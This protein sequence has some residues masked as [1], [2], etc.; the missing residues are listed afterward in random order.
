MVRP[1]VEVRRAYALSAPRRSAEPDGGHQVRGDPHAPRARAVLGARIAGRSALLP[2]TTRRTPAGTQP[3]AP[4]ASLQIGTIVARGPSGSSCAR[5]VV[6]IHR[7]QPVGPSGLSL[8]R[9][10]RA[11]EL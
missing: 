9:P 3:A 11:S 5:D 8:A 4:G 7:M 6:S 2:C 10:G 1:F